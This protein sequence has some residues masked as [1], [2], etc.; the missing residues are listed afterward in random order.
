MSFINYP[1]NKSYYS[2]F[3][4]SFLD[5]AHFRN[6]RNIFL[7]KIFFG[8]VKKIIS[9][10]IDMDI[11]VKDVLEIGGG[12]GIFAMNYKLNFPT[13]NYVLSEFLNNKETNLM[14]KIVIRELNFDIKFELG[15]DIQ[16]KT[17]YQNN[18]FDLIFALDVLEHLNSVQEAIDE[19]SRILRRNGLLFI[20]IPIEGIFVKI[21]RNVIGSFKKLNKD[22]HYK[23]SIKS[24]KDFYSYLIN[25]TDF[26]IIWQSKFPFH[27]F[28]EPF[29]YDF[30][31]ILKKN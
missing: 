22:P 20:S 7:S 27:G 12:F 6:Y 17:P 21:L 28:P 8:R 18:R 2:L 29:S 26:K 15:I 9:I 24:E 13:A 23:G 31:Y 30:L 10:L 25:R 11:K 1:K 5:Y 14:K 19:I 4:N 16:Q 3:P